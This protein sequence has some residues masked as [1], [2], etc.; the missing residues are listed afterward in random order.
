LV[1]HEIPNPQRSRAFTIAFADGDTELMI[2]SNDRLIR[3]ADLAVPCP[4][5]IILHPSLLKDDTVLDRPVHNVPWR[6]AFSPDREHVAVAYR[7][8]PLSVWSLDDDRPELIGRLMRDEEYAGNSWSVVDQVTWHPSGE[9]IVG[10]YLGG[11]VFRW[12]LFQNNQQELQAEASVL[13]CS[14]EGNFFAV[15][16]SDGTIKLYNYH[17]FALVYQLSCDS[18]IHDLCFSPDGKR[19][20]D[21]RGQYCNVWEPNALIRWEDGG[22]Q[23][24]EERSEVASI[25]T[26]AVSEAFTEARDQITATAIQFQGRYQALGNESGSISIIDT[27]AKAPRPVQIWQASVPLGIGFLAWSDDGKYLAWSDLTGRA[28]V[29]RVER[30]VA[31]TWNVTAMFDVKVPANSEGLH[32]L[33]LNSDGSVLMMKNGPS[34]MVW[35][36]EEIPGQES[37]YTAIESPGT[38]WIKHPLNPLVLLAVDCTHIRLH[39]WKDLSEIAVISLLHAPMQADNVGVARGDPEESRLVAVF[40][41]PAGSHCIIDIV[42]STLSGPKRIT[43]LFTFASLDKSVAGNRH[44]QLDAIPDELQ[45]EFEIMVGV[46]PRQR[47]VFLDKNF[48]MCSLSLSQPLVA[49]SVQRHYYLPKDWLNAKYLDHCA[50]LRDGKFLVPNNG[51]IAIVACTELCTN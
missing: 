47:L 5:W 30:S 22:E 37:N 31:D 34:A 9:S 19:I 16:T 7:N 49:A 17:H 27:S 39:R 4:A 48:W 32:Q 28:V 11:H 46:L 44:L 26:L 8:F 35:A 41:D 23:D 43:S 20:Y 13:A 29:K 36:V 24:S 10:L 33:L 38:K 40:A 21:V 2:G 3:T 1:L 14:P 45:Q 42:R 12:D 50:I 51:E 18:M 15:G 25:P 6:I